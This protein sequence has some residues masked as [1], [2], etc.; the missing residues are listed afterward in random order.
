MFATGSGRSNYRHA[1]KLDPG[2][3]FRKLEQPGLPV[4]QLSTKSMVL[5]SIV[6]IISVS[7]HWVLSRGATLHPTEATVRGNIVHLPGARAGESSSRPS[8]G[9]NYFFHWLHVSTRYTRVA[10]STG[11]RNRSGDGKSWGELLFVKENDLPSSRPI[12]GNN[13]ISRSPLHRT[14]TH[15][16][17]T[18]SELWMFCVWVLSLL[19]FLSSSQQPFT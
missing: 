11:Y 10:L 5:Q 12:D 16:E 17:V 19:P 13:R 8:L 3:R 15:V 18:V 9:D 1:S 14:I 2:C 6:A 4:D 7:C